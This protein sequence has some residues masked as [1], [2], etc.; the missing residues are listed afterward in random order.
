[1]PAQGCV[2]NLLGP[3]PV[4]HQCYIPWVSNT[5]RIGLR[6]L[7]QHASRYVDMVERGASIEVTRRGRTVARLIP[8]GVTV[9][10]DDLIGSGELTVPEDT[11]DLLAVRPAPPVT[12]G[13]SVGEELR[14][15][16]EEER[17]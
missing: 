8:A 3:C 15:L 2:G 12:D 7:R 1:M 4:A 11:D 16:R 17:W 9:D 5:E 10:L 6:E 14:R 13:H